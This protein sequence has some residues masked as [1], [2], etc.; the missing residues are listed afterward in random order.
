MRSCPSCPDQHSSTGLP[1]CPNED[2]LRRDHRPLSIRR[3]HLVHADVSA[4]TSRAGTRRLLHRGHRRVRVRSG[5]EHTLDGS[6]LWHRLYSGRACS[7]RSWR[8]LELRQLRRVISR[9]ERGDGATLCGGCGCLPQPVRGI[10]VLARRVR[11]IPRKAFI[12]SDPAFTQL[13]IAKAEP[14]YVAFFK[15]FDRLFTFGA[16]IG[17]PAS[18]I[19][20]G[21]FTWRK[22][23]QPV[24]LDQWSTNRPA[25]RLVHDGHD[26][27]D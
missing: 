19:P 21:D 5:P 18:P 3:R 4:G 25:R 23:W 26:L 9:P 2:S 17:T 1:S 20:V 14:W 6:R 7:I 11:R 27:A 10:V 22:T 13:A 15:Q 8:Q 12:D 16:N 24:T